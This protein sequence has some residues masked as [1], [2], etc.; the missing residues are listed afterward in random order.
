M[1]SDHRSEIDDDGG[2]PRARV[3]FLAARPARCWGGGSLDHAG[4]VGR[5]QQYQIE[6]SG[7]GGA[8]L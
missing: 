1:K 3:P 4:P 8:A 5:V 6:P 7:G 2:H